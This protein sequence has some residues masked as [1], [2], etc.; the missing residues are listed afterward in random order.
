MI[1]S[2]LRTGRSEAFST[3][4]EER[5]ADFRSLRIIAKRTIGEERMHSGHAKQNTPILR[6]YNIGVFGKV[7][8]IRTTLQWW[9]CFLEHN[10]LISKT[11]IVR[12]TSHEWSKMTKKYTTKLAL[13]KVEYCATRVLREPFHSNDQKRTE[14]FLSSSIWGTN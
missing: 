8:F 10:H 9:K 1:P 12:G 11:K 4:T 14:I 13:R 3:R 5:I 6:V 2:K 7:F